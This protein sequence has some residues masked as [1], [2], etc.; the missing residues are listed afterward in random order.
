MRKWAKTKIK[1]DFGK[2]GFV[3]VT[4]ENPYDIIR[5]ALKMEPCH[6]SSGGISLILQTGP[7]YSVKF[8]I[9]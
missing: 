8:L 9:S 3:W 7:K 5:L 1:F 2:C 6:P 4:M